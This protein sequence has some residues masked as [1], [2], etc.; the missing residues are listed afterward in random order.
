MT[1]TDEAAIDKLNQ[2]GNVQEEQLIQAALVKKYVEMGGKLGVKD[3]MITIL[4]L[5][6]DETILV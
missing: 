5:T 3:E 1:M 2:A 4:I 6:M